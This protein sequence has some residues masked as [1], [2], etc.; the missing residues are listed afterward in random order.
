MDAR[1]ERLQRELDGLAT[2]AAIES[3][4][5]ELQLERANLVP[6]MNRVVA[7]T[8]SRSRAHKLNA[9]LPQGLTALVDVERIEQAIQTLLDHALARCPRGCWIDVDLRRPLVGL[10]RIEIRDFGQPV[11]DDVRQQLAKGAESDRD[12]A[13][14]QSIV[15]LHGGTLTFEFPADG[16]VRAVVTLPTQRGKVA[17]SAT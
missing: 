6:L 16:G 9:A 12:L 13:L 4:T 17:A 11:S 15:E 7:R 5:L 8:R 10:A 3:S 1:S 14:V 2:R